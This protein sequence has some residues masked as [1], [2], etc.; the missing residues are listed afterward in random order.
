[1]GEKVVATY[2]L[3]VYVKNK[4]EIRKNYSHCSTDLVKYVTYV[5]W[6]LPK[7]T[8]LSAEEFAVDRP[9]RARTE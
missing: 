5:I 2:P 3:D 1:M 7:G 6:E 9:R 4:P 8:D